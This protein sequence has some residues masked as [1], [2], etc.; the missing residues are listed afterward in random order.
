MLPP[1]ADL[2][3]AVPERFDIVFASHV[4][5]HT[6]SLV[7]FLRSCTELLVP[8]GVLALVVPD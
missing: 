6:T 3:A 8:G 5:E 1:S 4:V 7:H 2:A